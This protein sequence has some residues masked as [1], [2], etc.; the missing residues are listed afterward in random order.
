MHFCVPLHCGTD[1]KVAAQFEASR[2]VGAVP[3]SDPIFLWTHLPRQWNTYLFLPSE[4]RRSLLWLVDGSEP[5]S[6]C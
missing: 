5:G 6:I 4:S 1:L 2:R 3:M